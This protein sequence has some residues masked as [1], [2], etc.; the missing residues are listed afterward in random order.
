[1]Y[2]KYISLKQD[3]DTDVVSRGKEEEEAKGGCGISFYV[4]ALM[5]RYHCVRK[6]VTC[7]LSSSYS[8]YPIPS[9]LCRSIQPLQITHTPFKIMGA[10]K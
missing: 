10:F 8:R 6:H 4:H 1:M 7:A 3:R 5:Q 9:S 2:V